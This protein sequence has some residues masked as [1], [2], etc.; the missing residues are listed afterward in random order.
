MYVVICTEYILVGR[1]KE[2]G[3]NIISFSDIITQFDVSLLLFWRTINKEVDV[4]LYDI[5]C[6]C[7]LLVD[8]FRSQG[9]VALVI[10]GVTDILYLVLRIIVS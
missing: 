8:A 7:K 1:D 3:D 5:S 10:L 2:V 9:V 4:P 6:V